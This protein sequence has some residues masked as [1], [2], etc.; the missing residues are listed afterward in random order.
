MQDAANPEMS[1]LLGK[2]RTAYNDMFKKQR[3]LSR[4]LRRTTPER[5]T[6]GLRVRRDIARHK[7][8]SE[9]P[10]HLVHGSLLRGH[11]MWRACDICHVPQPPTDPNFSSRTC[12][13]CGATGCESH[14]QAHEP[15]CDQRPS[16]RREVSQLTDVRNRSDAQ[17]QYLARRLGNTIVNTRRFAFWQ[18]AT[19]R[20][21]DSRTS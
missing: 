21:R 16:K 11:R 18:E 6:I 2:S 7:D 3:E 9:Q 12:G 14:V 19:Q 5:N 1:F 8:F 13:Y 15:H 4:A 20:L 10:F 17:M